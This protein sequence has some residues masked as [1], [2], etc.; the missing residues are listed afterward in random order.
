MV[1]Y[2]VSV[3]WDIDDILAHIRDRTNPQK[4]LTS[5]QDFVCRASAEQYAFWLQLQTGRPAT[6]KE[7]DPDRYATLRERVRVI[8]G[9]DNV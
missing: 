8:L 7:I 9:A 5:T 1:K 2:R 3:A 4:K 6:I